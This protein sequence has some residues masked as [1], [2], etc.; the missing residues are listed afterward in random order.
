MTM[1]LETT[2]TAITNRIGANIGQRIN[3]TF[4]RA[5]CQWLTILWTVLGTLVI[6][7]SKSFQSVLRKKTMHK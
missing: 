6:I 2:Q 1:C 5:S 3:N 4:D 7:L